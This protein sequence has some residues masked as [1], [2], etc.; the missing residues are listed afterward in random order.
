MKKLNITKKQYNESKYF[1]K[2]YGALKYMSESGKL[3]KTD[4][5]VVLALESEEDDE[6]KADEPAG[7]VGGADG[8]EEVTV[9]KGD[10]ASALQDVIDT[11]KDIAADNDVTLPEEEEDG[12]GEP[13]GDDD[14]DDDEVYN[15]NDF[16]SIKA[17][18]KEKAIS[19]TDY[20]YEHESDLKDYLKGC[21]KVMFET[22]ERGL[23]SEGLIN[24]E[25]N[26]YRVAAKLYEKAK[27]KEDF[28]VAYSYAACEENAAGGMMCTA[29]TLGA[30]GILTSLMYYLHKN[31]GVS[32]DRLCDLLAVAGIFGN[33][34][35][36]NASIAGST[37][38]CQA[39]VGTAC[40]MAA[41]AIA[42]KEGFGL[43]TIEYAAEMGIEHFLG[44]TCDPVLGYVIIPCIE[45]NAISILRAYD[46]AY[47]AE[48]LKDVKGN[49]ISFDSVVHAMN[50][51]GNKLAIELKET[52]LGGLSLE[53]KYE[54]R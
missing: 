14:G 3:Y 6:P 48:Q 25:L 41:A 38:G 2:K 40:S 45:R 31:E 9:K 52:S 21:L 35:K 32:E 13:G 16:D 17:F 18:L 15:E 4:K 11:V 20:I 33:C 7:L 27:S 12:E 8:E 28:L 47:L 53:Y 43:P 5:G 34:I 37:G 36:K 10:L 29:P 1:N 22:V 42:F 44:L 26:Y 19:L 51:T 23:T 50:Y 49:L 30:C 46:C 54:K 24:K 39:E